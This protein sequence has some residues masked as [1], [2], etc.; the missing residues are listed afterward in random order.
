MIPALVSS[1][2]VFDYTPTPTPTAAPSSF[3]VRYADELRQY[4]VERG[5]LRIV[6][7][8]T[9]FRD[10]QAKVRAEALAVALNRVYEK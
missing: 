8:P 4:V 10:E 9:P 7:T 1:L 2:P 6:P 5:T 3:T